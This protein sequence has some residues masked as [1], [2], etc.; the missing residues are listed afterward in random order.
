MSQFVIKILTLSFARI[1]LVSLD[2]V[3]AQ[4]VRESTKIHKA[5]WVTV[6]NRQLK[7]FCA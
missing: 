7:L 5:D 2:L 4:N 6:K 1:K 3:F